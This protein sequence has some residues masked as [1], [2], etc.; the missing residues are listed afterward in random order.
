MVFNTIFD[1]LDAS[2]THPKFIE[3]VRKLEKQMQDKIASA[4]LWRDHLLQNVNNQYETEKKQ[5]EVEYEVSVTF[6][7]WIMLSD[8]HANLLIHTQQA[9]R[10]LR[11]RMV[12]SINQKKKDEEEGVH[13]VMLIVML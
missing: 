3:Q 7:L 8:I 1:I 2:G 12:S 13:T 9:K 11:D 10:I 6:M 5:A 4:R